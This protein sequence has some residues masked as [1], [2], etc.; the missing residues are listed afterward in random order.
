MKVWTSLVPDFDL[1]FDSIE[2]DPSEKLVAVVIDVLRATSVM[3]TALAAGA[4]EVFTCQDIEAAFAISR[5]RR[6]QTSGRPLLCGERHCKPIPGFDLGNSPAE[7][8]A[9]VVTNRSLVMSTTN[10]TRAIEA[11]RNAHEIVA[12]S[13][14]NLAAVVAHVATFSRVHLICAG[15]DR[16]V[17]GEDVLLAGAILDRLKSQVAIQFANDSGRLAIGYWREVAARSSST[18]L[19]DEFRSSLGGRNLITTGYD[20][21]LARCAQIDSTRVVPQCVIDRDLT[22][23]R[24]VKCGVIE[25]RVPPRALQASPL[26]DN[27]NSPCMTSSANEKDDLEP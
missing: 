17:T 11:A 9:A 7:Y 25:H 4:A 24:F 18:K 22:E 27:A 23:R 14:L 13:F 3:T 5:R 1:N 15:T 19:V 6:D 16:H 21:D 26:P 8:S 2:Q 10:G 20:A 12:A